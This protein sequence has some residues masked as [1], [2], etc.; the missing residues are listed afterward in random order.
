MCGCMLYNNS[1]LV[2]LLR[3]QDKS[4]VCSCYKNDSYN[5]CDVYHSC[6]LQAKASGKKLSKMAV[7]VS[8]HGIQVV[9]MLTKEVKTDLSIYRYMLWQL[10]TTSVCLTATSPVLCHTGYNFTSPHLG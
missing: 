8:P 2:T 7:T 10:V 5:L 6:C 4:N 1:R 3:N 9:D